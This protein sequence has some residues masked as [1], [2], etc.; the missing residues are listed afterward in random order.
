MPRITNLVSGRTWSPTVVLM[1]F[2]FALYYNV[3]LFDVNVRGGILGYT[4]SI[5]YR[6]SYSKS[7]PTNTSNDEYFIEIYHFLVHIVQLFTEQ[8]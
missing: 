2:A 5:S 8:L 3:L 7:N 6:N 4:E 1:L